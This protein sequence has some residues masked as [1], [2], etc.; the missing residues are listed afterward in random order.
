MRWA[1]LT[2]ALAAVLAR[3]AGAPNFALPGPCSSSIWEPRFSVPQ[4]LRTGGL[5]KTLSLLVTT[6][7]CPEDAALP[8]GTPAP[9]LFFFNGFMVSRDQAPRRLRS[10]AQSRRRRRRRLPPASRATAPRLVVPL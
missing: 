9:V 8:F 5:P 4:E 1:V 6:P 10:T 7:V 3:A 2:M